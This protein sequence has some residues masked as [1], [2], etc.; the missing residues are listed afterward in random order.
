MTFEEQVVKL[1]DQNKSTY[2]I[3][4]ALD[5]YPNRV[6]RTLKKLGR[7]LRS[8]SESQKLAIDSGRAEHPSA[9]KKMDSSTKIKISSAVTKRWGG[10]SD[11][12]KKKF[13][14]EAKKRWDSLSETQKQRIR[15]SS[16]RAIREA[17]QNG[18]KLEKLLLKRISDYG[19]S[20]E[21]HRKQ[22]IPN[23]NLEIDLY[24]PSL[25]T[26]IEIDG[27]SHFLPLWGEEQLEKQVKADLD[28]NGLL[29]SKGFVVIRVKVLR[30]PTLAQTEDLFSRI[31]DTLDSISKKFPATSKRLIEVEING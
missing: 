1:Y 21:F 12:D 28:K 8:K 16:V 25:K 3:A 19:Y 30:T 23:V 11:K 2:E 24:I 22:L 20:V 4:D 7:T 27:P 10:L 5:T 6:A 13:S 15:D 26:I 9:G 31:R 17:S 18:S 14:A 29:L